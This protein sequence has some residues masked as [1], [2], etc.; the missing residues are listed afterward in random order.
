MGFFDLRECAFLLSF[1]S[2]PYRGS[3]SLLEVVFSNTEMMQGRRK[4]RRKLLDD[5]VS[6]GEAGD[7][8][9]RMY[10]DEYYLLKK[11]ESFGMP[12]QGEGSPF[13]GEDYTIGPCL[14]FE[15][16]LIFGEHLEGF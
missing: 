2:S 8:F 12:T 6:L 10:R 7:L 3:K 14:F 11:M 5:A 16:R 1:G 13:E 9:G 15:E 4:D